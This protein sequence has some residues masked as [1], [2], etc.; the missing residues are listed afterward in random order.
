MG[1]KWEKQKK[2]GKMKNGKIVKKKAKK[3]RVKSKI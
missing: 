3:N 1:E 2:I